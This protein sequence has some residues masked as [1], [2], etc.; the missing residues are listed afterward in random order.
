MGQSYEQLDAGTEGR[1]G[2]SKYSLFPFLSR[3]LL[4]FLFSVIS[5]YISVSDYTRVSVSVLQEARKP[6]LS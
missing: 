1:L 6:R 3:R 4:F 5:D 2:K